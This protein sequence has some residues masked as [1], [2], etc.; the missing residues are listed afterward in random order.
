MRKFQLQN[1]VKS[2]G[3]AVLMGILGWHY[4]YIGKWGLQLLMWVTFYGCF[5]W[6]FIDMF[7]AKGIVRR[8]NA[9][10]FAEIEAIEKQEKLDNIALMKAATS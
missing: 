4:A 10:I 8:H 1:Q 5:V 6:W 9:K 2:E 3:T 7:R